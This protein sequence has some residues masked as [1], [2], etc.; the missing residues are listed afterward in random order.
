MFPGGIHFYSS[1][2]QHKNSTKREKQENLFPIEIS[3]LPRKDIG[4]IPFS[5]P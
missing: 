4:E 2:K 5:Q 3:L 1:E